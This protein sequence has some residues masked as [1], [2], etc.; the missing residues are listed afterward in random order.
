MTNSNDDFASASDDLGEA[1]LF[2]AI[3]HETRIHALFELK[4]NPASFSD[5]KRKLGIS[6]SGNL[7]HH[8]RKL[9]PLIHV[10]DAG[11]YELTDQ[12]R[13]SLLAIRAVRSMQNRVRNNLNIAVI[14]GC[15]AYYIVQMNIPFLFGDVTPLT[16][17]IALLNA[18][19]F[20]L[21]FYVIWRAAF[22]VMAENPFEK[23][24]EA[25]SSS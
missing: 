17:I 21:V 5:L 8:I 7:Q 15:L 4:N 13:E 19:V 14:I 1:G 20:G 6:S 16:P 23:S 2:E 3:S 25:T 9:G 12:G 22:K 24:N 10:N 11:L 18:A